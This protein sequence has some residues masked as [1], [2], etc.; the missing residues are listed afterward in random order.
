VKKHQ[1]ATLLWLV[2]S[3][4]GGAQTQ[5]DVRT[6]TKNIDFSGAASTIPAKSGS[7]V[8]STCK[9]GE[10]FF[11]TNNSPGQNLYLCAPANTW[12]VLAGGGSGGST[13][14]T[15][16]TGSNGQFAYFASSG[17]TVSGHT[18]AASD[19]PTLNYQTPLT[20]T[21]TGSKTASSTGTTTANNCAKWDASG[22][23]V[24]AG[25]PCG[26]SGGS[27]TSITA[28]VL[29]SSTHIAHGDSITMGYLATGVSGASSLASA[30]DGL[31][32]TDERASLQAL[33][34]SGYSAC[35][36]G[37]KWVFNNDAI[38]P[39]DNSPIYTLMVGTNDANN[40]GVSAA[41]E[42]AV[43]EPCHKAIIAWDAL[44]NKFPATDAAHGGICTNSASGWTYNPGGGGANWIIPNDYTYTNGAA[45]TCPI[46]TYGG[47]IYFWY[48][49]Q[50]SHTTA[51]F[52]YSVDGGAATT[53]NGYTTPV[54]APPT[55]GVTYGWQLGR[56]PVSAGSHSIV[57]TSTGPTNSS[58]SSVSILAVG[59]PPATQYYGG[60]KI[61]VGG[62]PKM[63]G[64]T[65][66]ATFAEYNTDAAADVNQLAG[67]GLGV[68]FVNVRNYLCTSVV[69]GQCYNSQGVA[70]MNNSTVDPGQ[71]HPNAAGHN[72]LKQAF[73]ETMQFTPYVAPYTGNGGK[74]VTASAAGTSGDCVKW[75]ANGNIVDAGSPCGSGS[76][77]GGSGT[78][79][80][81]TAGQFAYYTGA[82][83]VVS[84][85]SLL[86]S[87]IPTLNYDPAG[88]A[89]T[90]QSQSLQK[91]GNLSDLA[92]VATAR[93]NLGITFTGSGAQ[94][95]TTT[96]AGTSG[97]CAKWDANGNV[98]DAGAP[99]GTGS[100]GG[101]GS[102]AWASLTPGT[103]TSGAFVLGSGAS[104]AATGAATI[105]AT[106]VP[107]TGI[108]GNLLDAQLPTDQ[109]TL[110]KYSITGAQLTSQA[111][112]TPTVQITTLASTNTRICLV[113]ISGSTS[114]TGTGITSA[115]VRLQ[116]GAATNPTL[117]SPNQ[118]LFG[119]VG[120]STNN[121]WTD[122]GNMA[123]RTNQN[124]V[125]AFTF[126]GA[127]SSAVSPGALVYITIG[128]RTMP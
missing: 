5:V 45:K 114:F 47:P 103:N 118:D 113:E 13:T 27:S 104:L 50:D 22:N 105:A 99:C 31:L 122:S 93:T 112:A 37:A 15:I 89:S 92:S 69:G 66:S 108:T 64:D 102:S 14:G 125:A 42:S 58:T 123:D 127:N 56:V 16:L 60:P 80:S 23:V 94:T 88:A 32:A 119:A 62:I 36:L 51:S 121:Y 61:F 117:Y 33:G 55:S 115:T 63:N 83:T 12:T 38:L 82:G 65:N 7:T 67:D 95:L 78:V 43:Y 68:Y 110:T 41:Y 39:A 57:F 97:N 20:F 24:D 79:N 52:T 120:P 18:L 74:T 35:D 96:G 17:T 90:A 111:S 59:T 81:G 71:L 128:T 6:Q 124:V 29:Q 1:L 70:D 9:V 46:T 34:Q 10:M 86:A 77:S 26:T 100:G 44:S 49:V 48:F 84:G 4:N 30:Y 25:T 73:E 85:H 54:I 75:D 109:C 21:G 11:N 19:I 106:S 2:S 53:L 116:S 98:V 8:P 126:V 72:D 87:D 76:G 91:S 101:S 28:G 107:A 40:K 3:F